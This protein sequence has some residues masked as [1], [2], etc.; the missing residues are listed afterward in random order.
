MKKIF[1]VLIIATLLTAVCA[2]NRGYTILGE[3]PVEELNGETVYLVNVNDG[4]P[5]DSAVIADGKFQLTGNV[6]GCQIASLVTSKGMTRYMSNIVLEKGTIRINLVNDSLSGTPMNDLYF[7]S[8]TDDTVAYNLRKKIDDCL[9][10]YYSAVTPE[11]Q[12][13]AAAEYN[14]VQSQ[15]DAHNLAVNRKVYEQNKDNIIGAYALTQ[16]VEY[17]KD[18][19]YSTLDSIMN[20]SGAAVSGFEPLQVVRKKLFN[21]ANT[22]EGKKYVDIDGIDFVTGQPTK[23]SDMLNAE[24]VTLIDFWASWCGP[25]RK[26]ISENLVRL[27]DKYNKKGLNIIGVDVW[28]KIPDH[29]KAVED[30]GI[31]YPQLIDTTR[32]ATDNY[33]VDGIPTILLLDKDG[34]ILK[35]NLRGEALEPAIVEALGLKK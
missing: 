15:L 23:L 1:N 33:G 7:Q 8:F 10:M 32:T 34:T 18:M 4:T 3:I 28:D 27:Y 6:E 5:I 2:C 12:V 22:S 30:L 31:A 14:V 29:K 11:E 13:S 25:C 20:Q 35:R 9:G 16:L 24:Q 26:E 17:D 21:I 19:N